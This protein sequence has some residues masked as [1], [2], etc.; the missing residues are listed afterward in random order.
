MELINRTALIDYVK[1]CS[2]SSDYKKDWDTAGVL[3]AISEQ[4]VVDA[5][6]IVN[7]K[8]IYNC[9][10]FTPHNRCSNCGYIKP[11]IACDGS[12]VEQEPQNYCNNCGARMD[13][14]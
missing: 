3:F 1:E 2:V 4:E 13:L 9:D 10:K 7:A 5:A 12:N 6:P 11:M 8:W 14:E